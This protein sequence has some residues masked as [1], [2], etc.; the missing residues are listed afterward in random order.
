MP[1]AKSSAPLAHNQPA[2]PMT[3]SNDL[4]SVM[5]SG[6]SQYHTMCA[7]G[8]YANVNQMIKNKSTAENF[9]RSANAPIIKAGVIAAKVNWKATKI[10]SGITTPLLKVAPTESG[11]IPLKNNLLKPP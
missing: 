7:I 1:P 2:L 5:A 6:P 8:K 3:V 9:I 10:N 4:A 11:V